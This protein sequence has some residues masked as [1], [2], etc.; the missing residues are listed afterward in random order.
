MGSPTLELV[1]A[2]YAAGAP[3]NA[4]H[5]AATAAT[6]LL[7]A[8]PLLDQLARLRIKYGFLE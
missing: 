7:A 5:G 1:V 3:V 2:I 4:I 8:N 6:L